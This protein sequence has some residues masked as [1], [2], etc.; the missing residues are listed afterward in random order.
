MQRWLM[1]MTGLLL[2][3]SL[4]GFADPTLAQRPA[5]SAPGAAAYHRPSPQMQRPTRLQHRP[6][7]GLQQIDPRP[8]FE[9]TFDD[10][11]SGNWVVT[12]QF[13]D[14]LD[15]TWGATDF[16]ADDLNPDSF[17]SAWMAAGGF[18]ALDPASVSDYPD[19]LASWMIY[20]PLDLSAAEY[21]SL[22]ASLFYDIE[23]GSDWLGLCVTA[24]TP[25]PLDALYDYASYPENTKCSWWTGVSDGWTS[26]SL[27]LR[28]FAG[29]PDVHIG[30]VFESDMGNDNAYIGAFVDELAVYASDTPPDDPFDDGFVPWTNVVSVSFDSI[31]LATDP[32][33]TL[34]TNQNSLNWNTTD[35]FNDDDTNPD[36]LFATSA[37]TPSSGYPAGL[38][39]GMIYGP[40]DLSDDYAADV[41]FSLLYDL[42]FSDDD[43]ASNDDWLGF[44]VGTSPDPADFDYESC[45]WWTGSSTFEGT[46]DLIWDEGYA[47]LSPYVGM[48]GIY[49]AWFFE[50]NTGSDS[51]IGAYVDEI[52]VWGLDEFDDGEIEFESEGELIENGDFASDLDEWETEDLADDQTGAVRVVDEVAIMEGNQYLYQTVTVPTDTIDLY[53]EFSKSISSTETIVDEDFICTALTAA[54][55]PADVLY[56]GGCWDVFDTPDYADDAEFFEFVSFALSD[57]DLER[58]RGQEVAFVIELVQDQNGNGTGETIIYV[59]DVVGY[60]TETTARAVPGSGAAPARDSTEP[61]DTFT[62]ATPISC[63]ETKRGV[64]GDVGSFWDADYFEITRAPSGTL[65]IDIN[66]ETLRPTSEADSFL[67]LY[68]AQKEPVLDDN[69]QPLE[70]DD[71]GTTRDSRLIYEN[72][73]DNATFYVEAESFIYGPEAFYEIS[74][75]CGDAETPP[76][77]PGGPRPRQSQPVAGKKAWTVMIYMSA[78]DPQDDWVGFAD[79]VRQGLEE[80]IGE[81]E[82]FLNVIMLVDGP[83]TGGIQSDTIRYVVQPG[84]NYTDGVNRWTLN[85]VNMG[86]GQTLDNFIKWAMSNYPAEHYLLSIDDHGHGVIG[87][88]LD[89]HGRAGAPTYDYLRLPEVRA[90]IKDATLNGERP[91]DIL[92]YEACWM[93]MVENAYDLK[94]Y[95]S[96]VSFYQPASWTSPVYPAFFQDLQ[97]ADDALTVGRRMV[98]SHPEEELPYTFA[99]IDTSTL[100]SLRQKI[101]DLAAALR[102]ADRD[103]VTAARNEAQAFA[104]DPEPGDA[105]QDRI[106]YI[107][108][109]HLADRL[110]ARGIA[111]SQA[112]A[113]KAAVEAAV[114]ERGGVTSAVVDG[115]Q[116]DYT[117]AHGLS[118]L[119]PDDSYNLLE[120]YQRDYLMSQDGVWDNYLLEAAFAEEPGIARRFRR[121]AN[122]P[123]VLE[124]RQAPRQLTIQ[125]RLYLPLVV[126]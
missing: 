59:D 52:E 21:A 36:S 125:H 121:S 50:S 101:D 84:G 18:D 79:E 67:A 86:D 85:E 103:E 58:V 117:N 114:L 49:L 3:S 123:L 33:W 68:D 90:A 83:N 20:G 120:D 102:T 105:A 81:K 9:E 70:N 4:V 34:F 19:N 118:I 72:P 28:R 110:A 94:D 45:E 37:I 14:S 99:L 64:F 25:D 66:A 13:T 24:G 29:Q 5:V 100:E 89:Y 39:N 42:V 15:I 12:D 87:V 69:N 96:Y 41:S 92:H 63:G 1:L 108:L 23:A 10:F 106:G 109:W 38:Q 88:A 43:D 124:P 91:I 115:V 75:S 77:P 60:A 112:A 74:V 71:D 55:D 54:D 30:W 61:N 82:E 122:F 76:P 32:A 47:D 22:D 111:T 51:H 48:S 113:V 65:V 95:A 7:S 31:D 40:L 2:C 126:R 107:D 53:F 93:G 56:D 78:E 27:D 98:Q 16:I 11:P 26:E 8:I 35:L 57:S 104:G 116:E 62:D 6:Q 97:A 46:D 80:F 17:N 119:Y 44:C 73:T